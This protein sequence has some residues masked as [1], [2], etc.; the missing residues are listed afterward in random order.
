MNKR[1]RPSLYSKELLVK[2]EDY[3]KNHKLYGDIV[4]TIKGLACHL[5]LSRETMQ[6]W[7]RDK[8]KPEF[9]YMLGQ[10]LD[11]QCRMLINGGLSGKFNIVICKL[12]LAKHGYSLKKH[13]QNTSTFGLYKKDN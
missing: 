1:G 8:E 10:L 7:K 9:S 12:I 5:H 4:P 3:I 13:R 2:T 6:A 11:K